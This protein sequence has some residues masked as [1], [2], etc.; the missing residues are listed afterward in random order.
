MKFPLEEKELKYFCTNIELISFLN[1][2][3]KD[4]N[5]KEKY[6]DLIGYAETY[7]LSGILSHYNM[8]FELDK[9]E[10]HQKNI[11]KFI[12]LDYERRVESE[13]TEQ[14]ESYISSL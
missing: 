7:R 14:F 12:A 13:K 1:N 2:F 3:K 5:I 9:T 11:D 8:P 4:L 6:L 10:Y